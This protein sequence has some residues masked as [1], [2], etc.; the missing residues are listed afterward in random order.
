[1]TDRIETCAAAPGVRIA[2]ADA[3]PATSSADTLFWCG[4]RVFILSR[5]RLIVADAPFGSR[6]VARLWLHECAVGG[7]FRVLVEHDA[8]TGLPSVSARGVSDLDAAFDLLTAR[9][10]APRGTRLS[11]L[12][13]EMRREKL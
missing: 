11:K 7:C 10:R 5:P 12:Q 8:W 9:K 1:M 13:H 6:P 3:P 4:D 2:S